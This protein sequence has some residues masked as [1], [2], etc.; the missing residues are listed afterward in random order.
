ML[1][2]G[3]LDALSKDRI[4][5]I[6]VASNCDHSPKTWQVDHGKVERLCSRFQGVECFQT[7]ISIP[8][9]HKRCVSIILR[10]VMLE[11]NGKRS[12]CCCNDMSFEIKELTY[13]FQETPVNPG[14]V[15]LHVRVPGPANKARIPYIEQNR[16]GDR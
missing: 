3:L 8:E 6:V 11:R 7:S 5:T 16:L 14:R 13:H 10:N 2:S 9:T 15:C 4:P 12:G 1:T